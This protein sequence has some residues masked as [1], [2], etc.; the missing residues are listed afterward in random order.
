MI[1]NIRK[2]IEPPVDG[3]TACTEMIKNKY[4]GG[5][6]DRIEISSNADVF[7]EK[8]EEIEAQEKILKQD[9]QEYQNLIK[10]LLKDHEE[11]SDTTFYN[12][13]KISV[14]LYVF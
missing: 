8:L 9:K 6:T 12:T 7:A 14:K 11:G 4:K 5:E 13:F 1:K 10:T 2:D 3:S